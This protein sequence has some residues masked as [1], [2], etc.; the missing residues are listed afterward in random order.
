MADQGHWFKLWCGADEDPDLTNLTI[1]DFG[2][3]CK[4][5]MYVKAHGTAGTVVL[6]PPAWVLCQRL[7]LPNF[8]AVIQTI[9]RFPHVQI[10]CAQSVENGSVTYVTNAT[11][12]FQN[13]TRYQG[14]MSRD[15]MRRL[16]TRVTPKRRGEEKR[17]PKPPVTQSSQGPNPRQPDAPAGA[18]SDPPEPANY[19]GISEA[20]AL[21][22]LGRLADLKRALVA[23]HLVR[24][25]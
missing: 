7:E 10:T 24:D 13:W 15:R 19:R 6:H 1:G 5:G 12:T 14:D 23:S 8:E 22:N 11:V 25:A 9:E 20:E 21:E 16:R 17:T 2:R 18:G 3:W 4:L